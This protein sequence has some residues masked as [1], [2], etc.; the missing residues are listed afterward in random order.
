M[1]G[2]TLDFEPIYTVKDLQVILGIGRDSSYDLMN[3]VGFQVSKRSKRVRRS[4][5]ID[6]LEREVS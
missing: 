2:K 3:K 4:V 6:Y 1:T 5:L